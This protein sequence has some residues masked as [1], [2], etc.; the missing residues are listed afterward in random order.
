MER[1]LVRPQTVDRNPFRR[2]A[3][4]VT[5]STS[6]RRTSG[7]PTKWLA[8]VLGQVLLRAGRTRDT[9]LLLLR[10]DDSLAG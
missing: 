8:S 6:K 5:T 4:A 10:L 2:S 1:R 7:S 3:S 9:S